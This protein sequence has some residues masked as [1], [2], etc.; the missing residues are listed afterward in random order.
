MKGA[1]YCFSVLAFCLVGCSGLEQ[2]E[3]EQIR[4]VNAK[5]D[6]IT[7]FSDEHFYEISFPQKKTEKRAGLKESSSSIKKIDKEQFRC[8]GSLS[9]KPIVSLDGKTLN[10]CEGAYKH[11][12]PIR[13]EKE[14]VYPALIEVLSFIQNRLSK[15]VVILSGHRCI[16][17]L[18]YIKQDYTPVSFKSLIGAEVRFYVEGAENEHDSIVSAI[19]SYYDLFFPKDKQ[20]VS[21]ISSSEN[22]VHENKELT[23]RLIEPNDPEIEE[24]ALS[25]PYYQIEL[26]FDRE[27]NKKISAKLEDGLSAYY[28]W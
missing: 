14:F 19:F 16:D 20:M 7:R 28:R 8:R 10:D 15:K 1:K 6:P 12:L 3:Q 18:R 23:V 4:K 26:K 17:H 5:V 2:S 22:K 21:F 25:F 11:S 24:H 13:A 27:L 9:N